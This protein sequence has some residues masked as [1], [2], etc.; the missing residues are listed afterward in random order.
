M[1][2]KYVK[3]SEPVE[4]VVVADRSGSMHSIKE[5]AIGGFNNFLKEQQK[6]DGEANLT[7]ILF[8]K[9]IDVA[10]DSAPIS[11]VL[12]LT[13]ETYIPAGM[14][15]LNDSIGHAVSRLQSKNAK[16]AIICIL[17]DGHENSSKEYTTSA[18]KKLIGE[19]SENWEVIYLAANQDAFAEASA[20]GITKSHNFT[21]DSKGISDAYADMS[22]SAS[23]YR[24][25]VNG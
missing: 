4:I 15:A 25:R 22:L 6:L 11:D 23:T 17:T 20:R 8:N 12:P 19:V 7:L 10:I 13:E 16:N 3:S 1:T 18:I 9:N 5:D 2:N 24:S 21:A 14:T